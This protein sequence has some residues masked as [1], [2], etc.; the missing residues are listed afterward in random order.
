MCPKKEYGVSTSAVSTDSTVQVPF[1]VINWVGVSNIFLFV[2]EIFPEPV[3]VP[4]I[5]PRLRGELVPSSRSLLEEMVLS[6]VVFSG[7]RNTYTDPMRG[8]E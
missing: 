7:Q 4:F 6:W 1:L 5:N 2:M 3:L 8:E